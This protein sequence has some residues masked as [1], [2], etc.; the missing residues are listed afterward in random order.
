MSDTP[1]IAEIAALV[2]SLDQLDDTD[3]IAAARRLALSLP[4]HLAVHADAWTYELTRSETRQT[5]GM[6]LGVTL[7]Q[8]ERAITRHMHRQRG[9][10]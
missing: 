2:A 10:Q 5:I 4:Q 8:I 9:G 6:R 7:S 1:S 3:R